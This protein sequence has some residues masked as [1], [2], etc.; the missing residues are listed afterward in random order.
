M[1]QKYRNKCIITRHIRERL[2]ERFGG[3]V[4]ADWSNQSDVNRAILQLLKESSPSK[5]HENDTKFML[6]MYD[7]Y[8]YGRFEFLCHPD[9]GIL[10]IVRP[11]GSKNILLTCVGIN[12]YSVSTCHQRKFSKCSKGKKKVKSHRAAR[13]EVLEYE[14]MM[15]YLGK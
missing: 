15:E 5:A 2:Q 11:D 4:S 12:E 8:G 14:A 3:V 13:D 10:F 1:D 6:A 9:K 7:R